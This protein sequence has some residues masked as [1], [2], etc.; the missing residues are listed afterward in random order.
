M[1]SGIKLTAELMVCASLMVF[2]TGCDRG[3][4]NASGSSSKKNYRHD[5]DPAK[6]LEARLKWNRKTLG[7]AYQTVGKR[8]SSWDE[9]ALKALE[10]FAQIRARYPKEA[11]PEQFR[12]LTSSLRA[13]E[14]AG[15]DDPMILYLQTRYTHNGAMDR[16]EFAT[17]FSELADQFNAG[18]YPALR[19][20]YATLRAAEASAVTI[21]ADRKLSPRLIALR[22]SAATNLIAALSDQPIPTEEVYEAI[23]AWLPT[24]RR[25]ARQLPEDMREVGPALEALPQDPLILLAR[26]ECAIA[27]AWNARGGGYADSVT[28]EAWKVF[29]ERLSEAQRLLQDAWTTDPSEPRIAIQML[30]VAVGLNFKRAEME[31]WFQRAMALNPNSHDAVA[32]KLRYLQP[33]WHGSAE[34]MVRFGQECVAAKEWGG[35]VP[36]LLYDAHLKIASFLPAQE[37]QLYWLKP[38]VWKDVSNSFERLF[39]TDPQSSGYRHDYAKQAFLAGQWGRF[40]EQLPLFVNG[41]N[42]EFF[43]GQERFNTMV[44]EA[45]QKS[46]PAL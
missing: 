30:E 37:Q 2:W 4:T 25:S 6:R 21:G 35:R 9:D 46:S 28:P 14:A 23:D 10:A 17:Q 5:E 15:C 31:K 12:I 45:R 40:L 32:G 22:Y 27:M 26:G 13:A 36:V 43:G 39:I 24:A 1:K 7:E 29:N 42:Y 3:K 16:L 44:A 11:D 34:E 38:T 19:R 18:N 33:Q 41:T 8:R 20:F